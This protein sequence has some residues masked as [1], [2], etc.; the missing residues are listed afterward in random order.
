MTDLHLT[1]ML[2]LIS[3]QLGTIAWSYSLELLQVQQHML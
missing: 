3:R 1:F 2:V